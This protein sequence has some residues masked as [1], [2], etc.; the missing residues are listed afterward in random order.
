MPTQIVLVEAG[1]VTPAA[2]SGWRQERFHAVAVVLDEP[3]RQ[4]I[5]REVAQ[6]VS[7]GGLGLYW[8]IEVARNPRLA[9]AH[10]RWM[11]ALGSH[12]DWLKRHPN[13]PK[14]GAGEV[15]KAF[16]WVPIGYHEAFQAHLKRIEQ[17]IERTPTGWRGLFLN[18][19]QGG[20]SSCGCGNLLCRW[21]LDYRVSSTATRSAGDDAAARFVAAVR[22]RVADKPV[23][24]VWT[25]ECEDVD[26]PPDK[27]QGRPGT[28]RC[29]TVGCSKG[30]CPAEFARQWAA[31]TS[32]HDGPIGLLA[33]HAT[34]ERIQPELGGGPGWVTNTIAHLEKTLA[35]N[36]G[37]ATPP[38]R[39][40]LVVEGSRPGEEAR[41]RELASKSR[42]GA[43][44]VARA[45]IDQSYEPRVIS[46]Q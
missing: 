19:L 6:R 46:T 1:A 26:L 30:A 4:T 13:C 18:D 43:V 35:A 17:L 23:I 28:G 36:G 38:E 33:L 9:A 34:L 3:M 40:W 20:P 16:P 42:V 29:G 14:P 25:T 21:A 24:P 2:V 27:N 15:A 41:A 11:A 37:K 8:W 32:G 10:P 12:D 5:C 44:I 22:R 39:L 45:R 7:E 31:L